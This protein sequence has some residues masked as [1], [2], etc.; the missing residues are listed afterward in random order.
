MSVD[1]TVVGLMVPTCVLADIGMDVPHCQTV[2]I[3][4]DKALKSKDLWR[5]IGQKS[6]MRLSGGLGGPLP[7]VMGEVSR[8]TL[9]QRTEAL[10]EENRQ[11]LSLV[12]QLLDRTGHLEKELGG[13]LDQVLSKL[14]NLQVGTLGQAVSSLSPTQ[15]SDAVSGDAPMFIPGSIT[16]VGATVRIEQSQ[17][18]TD[19]KGVSEAA[20]KLRSIRR[21]KQ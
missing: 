19:T 6:L 7:P 18:E 4:G 10:E 2:T 13:K 9:L 21:T 16:P 1:V 17:S 11:I 8:D 5:C 12:Q 15:A 3:P 20:G 14:N